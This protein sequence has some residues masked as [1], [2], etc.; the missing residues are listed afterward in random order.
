MKLRNL[1]KMLIALTAA[2]LPALALGQMDDSINSDAHIVSQREVEAE[3]IRIS[4]RDRTITVKGEARGETRQFTVPENTVIMVNGREA[5]LRDLRKGDNIKMS[6]VR[7]QNNVVV[8]QIRMPDPAVSLEERR[9]EPDNMV[10]QATP[11]VLPSTASL[12]PTLLAIGLICFVFAGFVRV[13]R[14]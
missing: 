6:F 11:A 1:S 5:R 2:A 12:N 4:P 8:E 10:A 14:T 9:A 3:V 7:R 13:I